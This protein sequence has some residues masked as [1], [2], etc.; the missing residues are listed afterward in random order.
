VITSTAVGGAE[1]QVYELASSFRSRGWGVGVVSMLS[2]HPQFLPLADAGV[3]LAS[4]EMQRGVPDPR[5]LARLARILRAWRPDVVH[6]HMVHAN[7][8]S[9][10]VRPLVPGPR[11]ISTMHSQDEGRQWRYYAY[12]LTDPLTDVTTTVSQL[13]IDEA[14]RRHAVPRDRILLVP[15]GIRTQRY[16]PDPIVRQALRAELSL[17]GG[18]TWLAVGSLSEA[19]RHTDL[20]TAMRQ[21]VAAEPRARLLVAGDGP[22]RSDL[23]R[24]VKHSGLGAAVSFLG[25]RDDVPALMQAADAFVMSSAWEGLPMVLLEASASALPIVATDVGGSRDVVADGRTGYLTAAGRPS[26]LART[27]LRLM[28]V[29][30]DARQA[31][32]D[33]SRDLV[34]QRFALDRIADAWESLYRDGRLEE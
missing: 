11:L 17:E 20:I 28:R 33:S 14:I 29:G 4:L 24:Q 16:R 10:L 12:R 9:R 8:M 2:L 19:K 6:G 34:T 23:E 7:L 5:A 30:V 25:V 13:A 15:N 32:G 27:M 3:R 31:M 26:G 1:R 21:V 18:F 22:L